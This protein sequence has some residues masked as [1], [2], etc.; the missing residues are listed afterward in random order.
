M[1]VVFYGFAMVHR[2]YPKIRKTKGER[3]FAEILPYEPVG[4]TRR[5][6]ARGDSDYFDRIV[7]VFY[8]CAAFTRIIDGV[9]D[10]GSAAGGRNDV[11]YIRCGDVNDADGRK[12]RCMYDKK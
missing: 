2:R 10:R 5:G 1:E 7:S 3:E 12:S 9:S 8:H 4:E 11:F 6:A